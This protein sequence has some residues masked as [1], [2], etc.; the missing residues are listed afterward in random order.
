MRE[1]IEILPFYRRH[2][3]GKKYREMI[4]RR[5]RHRGADH[6]KFILR[7]AFEGKIGRAVEACRLLS[8]VHNLPLCIWYAADQKVAEYA[9]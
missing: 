1:E 6:A 2:L 9:S 5:S 4:A 3:G 7:C 8:Q